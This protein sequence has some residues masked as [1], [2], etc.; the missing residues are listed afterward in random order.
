MNRSPLPSESNPDPAASNHPS[1]EESSGHGQLLVVP[2]M[3]PEEATYQA[4]HTL[5]SQVIE[6]D[7]D[8]GHETSDIEDIPRVEISTY[9]EI[10]TRLEQEIQRQ[11]DINDESLEIDS[12]A[13]LQV[14]QT[15]EV[16][17][18]DVIISGIKG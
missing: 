13:R 16:I 9:D 17:R 11:R 4:D 10:M 5:W 14:G 6:G 1:S 2:R 18:R 3:S 12:L 8:E 7:S 15:W